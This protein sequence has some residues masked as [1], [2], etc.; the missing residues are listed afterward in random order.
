MIFHL[1][2]CSG[3]PSAVEA[4]V[5]S[6][7]LLR[8]LFSRVW[9]ARVDLGRRQAGL[10]GKSDR[11]HGLNGKSVDG[12]RDFSLLFRTLTIRVGYLN[13]GS[14]GAFCTSLFFSNVLSTFSPKRSTFPKRIT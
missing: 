9:R 1:S 12:L 11:S 5:P 3:V 10:S 2:Q 7:R 8:R 13:R 6:P 4:F 14:N